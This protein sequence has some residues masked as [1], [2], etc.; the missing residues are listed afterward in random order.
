M[1]VPNLSG[2]K[3]YPISFTVGG[4]FYREATK[5]AELRQGLPN[6]DAVRELLVSNNLLQART[7]SS[8][9]RV[10]RELVQRLQGLT[11]A[12]IQLL[13]HGL[14]PEQNQVLWL[15]V[16]KQYPF[17]RQFAVE[18]VR[19]KYL[20]LDLEVTYRDFDTFYN[21]KAEWNETLQNAKASTRKKL[22]QVLFRMLLEAELISGTNLILPMVLTPK[23]AKAI[24]MDD[25]AYFPCFPMT[26]ADIKEL[27]K[28]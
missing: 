10:V 26:D 23:V 14:R 16:C 6:W 28:Q 27:N 15:A 2:A 3:S 5:A 24:A 12:E 17:I 21:G 19:E 8:L 7:P 4:L 1:P 11:E 22:R 25:P 13:V 20:R 9:R 18:V